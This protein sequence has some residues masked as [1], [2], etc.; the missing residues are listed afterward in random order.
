MPNM[1]E[2]SWD[3]FWYHYTVSCCPTA[4][5]EPLPGAQRRSKLNG[6]LVRA[7]CKLLNG[8]SDLWSDTGSKFGACKGMFDSKSNQ[9][10]TTLRTG[11]KEGTP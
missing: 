6:T 7:M 5:L 8:T 3:S 4:Q 10:E 11:K 1:T 2:I 9:H